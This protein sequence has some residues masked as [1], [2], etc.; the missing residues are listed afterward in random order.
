MR[1][2][3]QQLVLTLAVYGN[4]RHNM[5]AYQAAEIARAVVDKADGDERAEDLL[6]AFDEAFRRFVSGGQP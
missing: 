1:S 6:Q 2:Q 5:P 3:K 4:S